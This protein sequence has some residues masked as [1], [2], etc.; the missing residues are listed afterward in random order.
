MDIACYLVTKGKLEKGL[1]PEKLLIE[2][3]KVLRTEGEEIVHYKDKS[4]LVEGIYIPAKGT[5]TS[6]M[7]IPNIEE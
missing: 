5:K 1:L 7:L 4:I 2:L 3:A 6:I